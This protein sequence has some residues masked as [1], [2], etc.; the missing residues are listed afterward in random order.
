[1][2][3]G[4]DANPG[5][6]GKLYTGSKLE[7]ERLANERP[8]TSREQA[9]ARAAI[10]FG[11]ATAHRQMAVM[12][13][14]MVLKAGEYLDTMAEVAGRIGVPS[15]TILVADDDPLYHQ[16]FDNHIGIMGYEIIHA[17]NGEEAWR[18]IRE[19]KPGLV[20]LDC[21]MPKMMGS[22]V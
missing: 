9:I 8:M 2:K 21:K 17:E 6:M 18:I 7:L 13:G 22:D 15:S 12:S 20:F 1:M 16:I 5:D 4:D 3:M 19:Q 11:F 10:D 14:G